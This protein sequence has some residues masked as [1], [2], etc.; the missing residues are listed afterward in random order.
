MRSTITSVW[1][2][3]RPHDWP[4]AELFPLDDIS[5]LIGRQCFLEVLIRHSRSPREPR[6]SDEAFRLGV[7]NRVHWCA[8]DHEKSP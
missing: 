2:R 6:E 1:S 5:L 3:I 4:G 7:A 8:V